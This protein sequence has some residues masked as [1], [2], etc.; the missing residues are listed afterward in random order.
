MK[1]LDRRKFIAAAGA[2]GAA[3]ALTACDEQPAAPA[4]VSEMPR[5]TWRLTSS[6]PKSLDTIYGAADTFARRVSEMT[7]GRFTIQ[8]FAAGEIVGPLQAADAVSD[9]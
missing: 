6:F 4:I 2:G 5:L 8:V 3:A 7:D 9:G 1:K